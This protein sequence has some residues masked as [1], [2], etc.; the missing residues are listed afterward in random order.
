LMPMI[1]AAEILG[2]RLV[3][4]SA[5]YY[6]ILIVAA[7]MIAGAFGIVRSRFG[8]A[9]VAVRDDDVAA[10]I[11]GINVA[12][13]KA[14]AFLIGAF[15]A[16]VGGALWAYVIRFVGVDQFTLFNSVFFIAMIVVGGMGSIVGA[17]IGVFVIRTIQEVIAT[18]GPNLAEV[19]PFIGGDIVFAGMNVILGGVIA[20]FMILEPKGLMHRWSIV[21]SS[22]R[23]WPFPY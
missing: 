22:Y 11:M 15:Y 10:G 19:V 12:R 17:L 9:F 16:G 2:Y 23:I 20:L 6:L 8:R 13:T 4:D 18:V 3:D 5:Q 14:N 7:V 1:P 21:K